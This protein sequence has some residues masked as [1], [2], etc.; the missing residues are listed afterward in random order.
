MRS[1]YRP[2]QMS[3]L[4]LGQRQAC[5]IDALLNQ[6]PNKIALPYQTDSAELFAS[7]RQLP[8]PAFLDSSDYGGEFGRFDILCADPSHLL[9]SND[10]QTRL[11]LRDGSSQPLTQPPFEALQQLLIEQ[12]FDGYA[13]GDLPFC[14]GAL[15]YFGYD[16]GRCYAPLANQAQDDINLPQMK[17]GIYHWAII[18]DH[19]RQKTTLASHS[20][21]IQQLQ[22]IAD[23]A[24]AGLRINGNP[25]AFFELTNRFHSNL[26]PVQYRHRFEQVIDYIH[27]GD[28]YQINLAQ[29][30]SSRYRGDPW[31][32]YQ[33]LRNQTRTPFSA[34]LESD[35]GCL[36]SLSPERFLQVCDSRV[37]TRPIKGTRPRHQNI[38][39]DQLLKQQLRNSPKDRAENL[40]IVDLLRN[41]LGRT[42][43]TGSVKV[44]E[45]FKIES[46]ANVHHLVTS[47]TG[48]LSQPID[49]IR[50]LRDSFPGGSITGA[51]KVRAMQIIEELEPHRRSAY[52][53]SIG[54]IG[55]NGRMDSNICIRTLVATKEAVD[56]NSSDADTATS[57][58]NQGELHCWAGGGI[59]ADSDCESEYQETFDKVNN[60]LECLEREFLDS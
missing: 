34:Y 25:H 1:F 48:Q 46:Y 58:P 47:I 45:L 21:N 51:P 6:P 30:F 28:C 24:C 37:E 52:C 11:Q 42:C 43:R 49:A 12:G 18:V 8:C 20:L 50:L 5:G 29:R 36:L 33:Q 3:P 55:F 16:L 60:L 35:S 2:A 4:T 10:C 26:S 27:S 32:A 57:T 39:Q 19:Q 40:M 44:P 54:Y 38:E 14:G 56:G 15:G 53:G 59:V 41:D 9:I 17:M 31:A 22:V 13:T 23:Q 7:L